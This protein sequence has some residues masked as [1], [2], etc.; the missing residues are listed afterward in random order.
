MFLVARRK[1]RASTTRAFDAPFQKGLVHSRGPR[2]RTRCR[3]SFQWAI[4]H[5]Q[6]MH[7]CTILS[8]KCGRYFPLKGAVP[9]KYWHSD[10]GI[11]L[12]L[13]KNINCLCS[14][15]LLSELKLSKLQKMHGPIPKLQTNDAA[16]WCRIQ[17]WCTQTSL[18]PRAHS[19]AE[20]KLHLLP[21]QR[22]TES[23]FSFSSD[24]S[25]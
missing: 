17:R 13:S 23:R 21:F 15:S 9:H 22:T 24:G 18:K 6:I 2:D 12:N 10:L 20:S 1:A 4:A 3:G 19:R 8:P 11:T 25:A 14:I 7:K 5:V 16:A